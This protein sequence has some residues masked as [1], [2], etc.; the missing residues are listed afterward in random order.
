MSNAIHSGYRITAIHNG[1]RHNG[2]GRNHPR[3]PT[4]RGA[5]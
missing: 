1:A 2:A 3:P 5:T 4:P